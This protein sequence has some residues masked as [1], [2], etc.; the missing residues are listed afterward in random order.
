MLYQRDGRSP[1]VPAR[2]VALNY[3]RVNWK[4][5]PVLFLPG[6]QAGD[7]KWVYATQNVGCIKEVGGRGIPPEE[8]EFLINHVVAR[9]SSLQTPAR[10]PPRTV[11]LTSSPATPPEPQDAP[12]RRRPRPPAGDADEDPEVLGRR[13][14]PRKLLLEAAPAAIPAPVAPSPSAQEIVAGVADALGDSIR[15]E[16]AAAMLTVRKDTAAMVAASRASRTALE[17]LEK[18]VRGLLRRCRCEDLGTLER[19]LGDLQRSSAVDAERLVAA[20]EDNRRLR[21]E[22]ERERAEHRYTR[23][24]LQAALGAKGTGAGA[25]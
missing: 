1:A 14:R 5:R 4:K 25:P 19:T 23:G 22:L 17:A 11:D 9:S 20:A 10:P 21:E 3:D 2:W 13:K 15:G 8:G 16:V 12:E 18:H 24:L 7:E 6:Q